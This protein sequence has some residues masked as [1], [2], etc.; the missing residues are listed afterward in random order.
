MIYDQETFKIISL[1]KIGDL[2][3]R[4]VGDHI[5]I[6]SDKEEMLGVDAVYF[7]EP[8]R[9]NLDIVLYDLNQRYFDSFYLCF[10]YYCLSED[11]KYFFESAIRI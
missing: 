5:D 2:R 3:E 10:S 1:F 7:I 4:F 11:L 8:C 9:K 6:Q